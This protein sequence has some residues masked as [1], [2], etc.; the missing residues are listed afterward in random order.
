MLIPVVSTQEFS[1]ELLWRDCVGIS[2]PVA[3]PME[4]FLAQRLFH[5]PLCHTA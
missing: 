4:V 2:G 1:C 3:Q 5:Q